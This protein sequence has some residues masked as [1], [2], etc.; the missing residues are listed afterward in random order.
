LGLKKHTTGAEIFSLLSDYFL[1]TDIKM[2][3]CI[4]IC[5]DAAANMTGKHAELVAKMKQV[6][7]NLQSTHCMIHRE[8]QA[9]KIMSTELNQVLTTAVKTVHLI[10]SLSSR[11]FAILCDEM[12]STH[13]TILL[14]AEVCWFSR[15]R[16]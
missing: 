16:I 14:H 12:G 13:R 11:L 8:M 7:P 15:G 10:H 4:S 2:S 6:A 5:T 1:S 3:D 9:S